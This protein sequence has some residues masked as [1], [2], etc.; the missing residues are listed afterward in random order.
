MRM[1][2][3]ENSIALVAGRMFAR[4][5]GQLPQGAAALAHAPASVSR[6]GRAPR[7][8]WPDVVDPVDAGRAPPTPTRHAS[9]RVE[10]IGPYERARPGDPASPL[11]NTNAHYWTALAGIAWDRDVD[12][13]FDR[14]PVDLDGDGR[15]TRRS[16]GTSTPRAACSPTRRCS[17]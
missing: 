14:E 11:V 13:D 12:I 7:C 10:D 17:A 9:A 6:A 1:G 2:G 15:R 5:R 4:R 16:R 8:C 3:R